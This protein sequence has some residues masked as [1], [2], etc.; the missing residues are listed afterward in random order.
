MKIMLVCSAKFSE[1]ED[2]F[3]GQLRELGHE[4]TFTAGYDDPQLDGESFPDYAARMMRKSIAR[5]PNTDAVLCLNFAQKG[6]DGHIGG[7]TFLELGYAFEHGKKIF[8]L[9]DLPADPPVGMTPLDELEM[10]EPV[11]LNGDLGKIK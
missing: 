7:A 9:N 2:E 10:F 6:Q 8:V 5:M 1:R 11:V 3:A 4:V